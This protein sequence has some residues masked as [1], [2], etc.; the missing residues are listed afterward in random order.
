MEKRI[1]PYLIKSSTMAGYYELLFDEGYELRIFN[2]QKDKELYNFFLPD[3]N[4]FMF[5]TFNMDNKAEFEK[6]SND[7]KAPI[8]SDYDC[9]ILTKGETEV[10][11]FSTGICLAITDDMEALEKLK[12]YEE[13]QDV[14]EINVRETDSYPVATDEKEKYLYSIQLYKMLYLNKLMKLIQNPALFDRV[15]KSYV[16]F[17]TKVYNVKVTDDKGAQEKLLRWADDFD[18]EK[19]YVALDNEFDLLYKNNKINDN[20]TRQK[21]T[22]ALC[23]VLLVISVI[24]LIGK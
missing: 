19:K 11:C 17:T 18:L 13:R 6:L 14:Q 23:V 10:I 15:R 22:M 16:D 1:Y 5:W 21:I 12:T 4:N 3:V 8:C 9:N 20:Q 7:L 24:L 2:K